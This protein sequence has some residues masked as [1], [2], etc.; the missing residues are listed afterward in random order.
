M[1]D[2]EAG[3]EPGVTDRPDRLVEG[4]EVQLSASFRIWVAYNP[5]RDAVACTSATSS[6][7]RA[8]IPGA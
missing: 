2:L 1:R 8:C 3:A 6:A 4:G 5:P 7:L